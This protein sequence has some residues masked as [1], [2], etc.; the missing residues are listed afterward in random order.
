MRYHETKL[1]PSGDLAQLW[2]MALFNV[3]IVYKMRSNLIQAS[4]HARSAGE[5][6][7][8]PWAPDGN[9]TGSTIRR[10]ETG[11]EEDEMVS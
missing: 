3:Q 1:I 2:E 5:T 10:K 4:A 7:W 9:S 6:F 8:Y 11:N